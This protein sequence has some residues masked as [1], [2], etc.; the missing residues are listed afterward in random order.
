LIHEIVQP[1]PR[2]ALPSTTT[3]KLISLEENE[4]EEEYGGGDFYEGSD[5]DSSVSS[6]SSD[7]VEEKII[8]IL[9]CGLSSNP[10]QL[11]SYNLSSCTLK[12]WNYDGWSSLERSYG[13]FE[14]CLKFKI[15]SFQVFNEINQIFKNN[16]K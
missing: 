6:V 14:D 3:T 1:P 8:W 13:E 5:K 16:N 15:I 4:N 10:T 2:L 11:F 9:L 12:E 7:Q